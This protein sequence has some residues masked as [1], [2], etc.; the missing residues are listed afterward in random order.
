ML[1]PMSRGCRRRY[2]ER[3]D[4]ILAG[5]VLVKETLLR[6]AKLLMVCAGFAMKV[7]QWC[8]VV[9]TAAVVGFSG[10]T[11][12]VEP[13]SKDEVTTRVSGKTLAWYSEN[14]TGSDRPRIKFGVDGE[15]SLTHTGASDQPSVETGTWHVTDRGQLCVTV[16]GKTQGKCFF[17]IPTGGD[18]YMLKED[19]APSTGVPDTAAP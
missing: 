6:D 9:M 8:A 17:L 11:Q 2:R 1:G 16:H 4:E 3:P 15:F 13:L 12:A 19:P 7:V 5:S 14:L 18:S 10:A